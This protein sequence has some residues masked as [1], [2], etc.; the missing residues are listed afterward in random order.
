MIIPDTEEMT[1]RMNN[2]VMSLLR[3]ELPNLFKKHL[4]YL[5]YQ[6]NSLPHMLQVISYILLWKRQEHELNNLWVDTYTCYCLALS[7]LEPM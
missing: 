4:W 1:P 5:Y 3:S 6:K 7:S 2:S